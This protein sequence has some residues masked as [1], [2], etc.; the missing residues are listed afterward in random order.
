MAQAIDPNTIRFH[1]LSDEMLADAI[2]RADVAS[3]GTRAISMHSTLTHQKDNAMSKLSRRSLVSSAAALPALAIPAVAAASTDDP[4]FAA[5]AEHKSAVQA[6]EEAVKHQDYNSVFEKDDPRRVAAE[7]QYNKTKDAMDDAGFRMLNI[8]PTSMQGVVA[9][10]KYMIDNIEENGDVMGWPSDLLPDEVDPETAT[11]AQ[12]RSAEY[13]L[14]K[15]AVASLRR[16]SAAGTPS[17]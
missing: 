1:N 2:G 9:L 12:A 6:F 7:E 8:E 17:A 13:F 15:S 14:M 11:L 3:S 4:I 10:L 16:L 5:L